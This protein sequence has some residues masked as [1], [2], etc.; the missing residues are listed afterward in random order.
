MGRFFRFFNESLHESCNRIKD[1]LSS[2]SVCLMPSIESIGAISSLGGRA[3]DSSCPWLVKGM[4]QGSQSPQQRDRA[5]LPNS[6]TIE[7]LKLRNYRISQELN[8]LFYASGIGKHDKSVL[9]ILA[10]SL[11]FK[12]R[13]LQRL[14]EEKDAR[15][16]VYLVRM[17]RNHTF[18]WWSFNG[19]KWVDFMSRFIHLDPKIIRVDQI[20]VNR[21]L[22]NFYTKVGDEAEYG[23]TQD[24]V[25][26]CVVVGCNDPRMFQ[27][28]PHKMLLNWHVNRIKKRVSIE[29]DGVL[30]EIP[31]SYSYFSKLN[32]RVV[33][34]FTV[35]IHKVM[36]EFMLVDTFTKRLQE[37]HYIQLR[38]H[39][40][41]NMNLK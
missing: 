30:L 9:H 11:V 36:I 32:D 15:A 21:F 41:D 31:I 26:K 18:S 20:D 14:T 23:F 16:E 5:I 1:I 37:P 27:P 39:M 34:T 29:F 22:V 24:H 8:K 35:E 17:D 25:K 19:T 10:S 33:V 6:G 28:I 2:R 3:I 12:E 38:Q 13:K 40:P 7:S 4:R